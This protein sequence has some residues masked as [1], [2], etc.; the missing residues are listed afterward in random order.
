[1]EGGD[2]FG[3]RRNNS[4]QRKCDSLNQRK[5]SRIEFVLHFQKPENER[6]HESQ[7]NQKTGRDF[8]VSFLRRVVGGGFKVFSRLF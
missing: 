7:K 1:L 6:K 2:G 3:R 5:E 4:F 8:G